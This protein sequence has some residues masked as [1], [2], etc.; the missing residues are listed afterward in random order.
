MAEIKKTVRRPAW[1]I[2]YF[3]ITR[4]ATGMTGC[5][6]EKNSF[7]ALARDVSLSKKKKKYV[8]LIT[9]II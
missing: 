5:W 4:Q 2:R 1:L 7:T 3:R 8:F 6:V 9:Y